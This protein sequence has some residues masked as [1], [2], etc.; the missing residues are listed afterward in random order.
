M[1]RELNKRIKQT[2]EQGRTLWLS[3]P[4]LKLNVIGPCGG[5]GDGGEKAKSAL[6]LVFLSKYIIERNSSIFLVLI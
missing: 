4:H 1:L 5:G 3:L 6:D 2:H